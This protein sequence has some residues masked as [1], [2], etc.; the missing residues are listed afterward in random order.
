MV[1]VR[2]P[3]PATLALMLS[4]MVA[5][6][7][8]SL[9]SSRA[10]FSDTTDSGGNSFNAA[11]SWTTV[12][13]GT[14]SISSNGGTNTLTVPIASVDPSKAFLIFQSRHNGNRPVNSMVR[15]R[16]ASATSL[17]FV[18]VSDEAPLGFSYRQQ[19]TIN[20]GANAPSGGYNG[21][22]IRVTGIDTQ[23][24]ISTGKLLS[25]G[26]D[27][28]IFY[29]D[30]SAWNEVD[31]EVRNLNT[32]STSIIFKS[33]TDISASG[34][35]NDHFL[36]YG[37]PDALAP[38]P[39]D[40]TNVYVW[41]DDA[42]QDRLSQYTQGRGDNWHSTGWADS[43]AWNAAG[44]YTYDTGDNFTDSLRR[45]VNERDV[46]VEAE[47]YH[48][49]AYP[50]DM[51][52]GVLV[53]YQGTGSGATES[54]THYYASN[55]AD[56]PFQTSTGYSHD[57]SIMKDA[58]GTIAIGPAEG[59]AAPAIT[60]GQWRKQALAIW[61]T[62]DTNGK[63]WDDNV[64]TDLTRGWPGDDTPDF[65]K[66]GTDA[67]VGDDEGAGDAGLIVAQD[68]A[69]VRRILIRRYTEPEP[70]LAPGAE[71]VI[72]AIDIQ[73]YVVEIPTGVNV[74][75]G[76]VASQNATTIN[77]PITPVAAMN[78]AFVTWSKTPAATDGTF[79][80]DDPL[81]GELTST[82]NLQFRVNSANSSHVI[83]WQVVEFTN[84]AD[85]NVQ[86][87]T[88]SLL[89]TATSTNVTLGTPVDVNST[90]L[91]VGFRTAGSG[92]DVG[93]RML[94]ARLVDSSTITIDRSVSGTPDDITEI[95]WQAV[96][97]KNGSSVQRGSETFLTG[98]AQKTVP[99]SSV[100]PRAV[101]FA[102]VQPV[103]GQNMG[104][105][106]YAGDD[107][108]GVCSVTMSLSA[109][110]ITMD[111]NNTAAACDIGWFV[112]EFAP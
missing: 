84:S 60:T 30:G 94:R 74:Q 24:L 27:L 34:S 85:I 63:F 98:V 35:D 51:T 45:P 57:V 18:R 37:N 10:A 8:V 21:Y 43:F 76:E 65:L 44:Y 80:S 25:D 92:S 105:S 96:E 1:E 72:P 4:A 108:V 91:L 99:I 58:R 28:R 109:T 111:R 71:E 54:S 110:Q 9:P 31:R 59:S 2:R 32:T 56:S 15:G 82:S 14:A 79:S 23:S 107:I 73:W 29:W 86:K 67:A 61:G 64:A 101:A 70:V 16:I 93:S 83:W 75:R 20:V 42:S 3:Q 49:N 38:N 68:A 69:R 77:V 90:F 97:F 46:L 104:R 55:R 88:T 95:S 41:Y 53:R 39:L 47:F 89:G 106:A 62:N 6:M 12:Q 81:V 11:A 50:N 13:S 5:A 102:S 100:N 33:Q 48:T 17:E 19:L 40:T 22:T 36:F 66:S 103:G 52:S 7:V 87:G 112:V 26:N 78:Q